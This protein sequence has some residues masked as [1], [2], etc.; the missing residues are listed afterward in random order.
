VRTFLKIVSF[1]YFSLKI[2]DQTDT[3]TLNLNDFVSIQG[4]VIFDQETKEVF[5]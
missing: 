4:K 2:G 5:L 1:G 3:F